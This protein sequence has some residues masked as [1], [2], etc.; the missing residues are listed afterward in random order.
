[1]GVDK[2]S[3]YD[4]AD[5]RG[6]ASAHDE[7]VL[8]EVLVELERAAEAGQPLFVWVNLLACR[9]VASMH[10]PSSDPPGEDECTLL[11]SAASADHVPASVHAVHPVARREKTRPNGVTIADEYTD[12]LHA[13]KKA[14]DELVATIDPVLSASLRLRAHVA[15]TA[16]H[17]LAIGEHGLYGGGTLP[18]SICCNTLWCSNV[19]LPALT[20]QQPLTAL[21]AQWVTERPQPTG[22]HTLH[23]TFTWAGTRYTRLVIPVHDHQYA[24][25]YGNRTVACVYDLSVDPDE[26]HDIATEVTHLHATF[27]KAVATLSTSPTTETTTPPSAS[28]SLKHRAS[29]PL[30]PVMPTR[31][32]TVPRRQT[33]P[34]NVRTT[35]TRI[36]TKH[37]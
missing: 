37:R 21:V 36:N 8:S 33:R 35:E 17:L 16:S 6:R 4:T 15:L 28:T 32:R 14:V 27:L 10:Y 19:S 1:M 9:D 18:T 22:T 24:V 30:A 12:R 11:R 23:T 31:V 2:C 7:V 29:S 13:A 25:L 26:V 5:A 20:G 34:S 3:L